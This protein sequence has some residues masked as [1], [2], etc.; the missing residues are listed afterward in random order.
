M[1][2]YC[3]A[4]VDHPPEPAQ[5]NLALT[6]HELELLP[7]ISKPQGVAKAAPSFFVDKSRIRYDSA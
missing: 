5:L 3:Q 4:S 7:F 6:E 1:I 2:S